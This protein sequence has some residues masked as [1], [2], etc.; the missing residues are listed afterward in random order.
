[1]KTFR[2]HHDLSLKSDVLLLADVFENFRDVCLNN[3]GLD[4][5]WCYT[6]PGL[7]WDACLQHTKVN[8]ELLTDSD[9]LLLFGKGIREGVSKITTRCG[10]ANNPYTKYYNPK[11]KAKYLIY[12]DMDE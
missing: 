12:L 6:A 4:P 10:K 2:E 3:Y 8:L 1:M 7:A 9:M 11:E 5:A